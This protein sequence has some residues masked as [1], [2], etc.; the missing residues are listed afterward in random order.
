MKCDECG[1]IIW[2]W[3]RRWRSGRVFST[4]GSMLG[5]VNFCSDECCLSYKEQFDIDFRKVKAE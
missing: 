1:R 2:F 3:N 5:I 4:E